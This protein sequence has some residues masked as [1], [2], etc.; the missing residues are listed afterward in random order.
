MDRRPVMSAVLF[1]LLASPTYGQQMSGKSAVERP[2]PGA[3][4]ATGVGATAVMNLVDRKEI[5][6][7]VPNAQQGRVDLTPKQELEHRIAD[8][9]RVLRD[10]ESAHASDI[11]VARLYVQLGLWYQDLALWNRS[12]ADLERAVALFRRAS[13]PESDERRVS[14]GY[15]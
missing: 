11:A 5:G 9:E 2:L 8:Y 3:T 1:L 6:G 10:A 7:T 4:N 14:D 13:E 12:E 15:Q